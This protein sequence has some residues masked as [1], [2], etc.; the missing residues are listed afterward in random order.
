MRGDRLL[1]RGQV[2]RN[3]TTPVVFLTKRN[4][5]DFKGSWK[6]HRKSEALSKGGTSL[7]Y[8]TSLGL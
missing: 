7:R 3:T 4:R 5:K 1:W 8:L 6:L 2:S